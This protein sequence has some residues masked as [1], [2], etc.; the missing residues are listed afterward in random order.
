MKSRIFL[1]A[2]ALSLVSCKP[3]VK[4]LYGIKKP[5]L[6]TDAS[7]KRYITDHQMDSTKVITFPSLMSFVAASQQKYLSIPDAL[8]FNKDG[9]LVPYKS[10]AQACNADVSKFIADLKN[11]ETRPVNSQVR[12]AM[13][14]GMLQQKQNEQQAGVT[15]YITWTKF[16]GRLNKTKAFEWVKALERAR[17]EGVQVSYYLL[18][19]DFQKSWNLSREQL[20]RLNLK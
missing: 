10:S 3:I 2:V 18:N 1:V 19:C 11:F 20:N 9:F 12:L 15:A 6:E 8:F 5:A 4:T 13:L 17:Q 14:Q 16:S 7:I